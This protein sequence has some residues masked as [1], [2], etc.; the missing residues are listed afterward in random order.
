M[1]PLDMS[2]SGMEQGASSALGVAAI[3][4]AA[5]VGCSESE[6]PSGGTTS[7]GGGGQGAGTTSS[8][9]SSS[10][11]S[12]GTVASGGGGAGGSGGDGG[13]ACPDIL[14]LDGIPASCTATG[15]GA[16]SQADT[17]ICPADS[18]EVW[19]A[20]IYE[21]PVSAGDCLSMKADNVGSP[22]GADLFGAIVEPGGKSLLYDEEIACTVP[23]P[24]GYACPAGAVIT[25]ASGNAY[26]MVG[27]WE[28]QGCSAGDPT[29]FELVV[30]INGTD[31][32]LSAGAL[33]TGDLLE[34]IP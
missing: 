11:G 23:N 12:G 27:S 33:C 29:P 14:I 25:E 32:D 30:A 26:V 10:G 28:G 15:T 4:F 24:E 21:I 6:T 9:S 34:I 20:T 8:S 7:T 1:W 16:L 17:T 22:L 19:P 13:T 31:V 5:A 2:W 18:G 3:I